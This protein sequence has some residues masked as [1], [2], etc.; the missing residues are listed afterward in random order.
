MLLKMCQYRH[1]IFIGKWLVKFRIIRNFLL[2]VLLD[3]Y[4][5]N[6]KGTYYQGSLFENKCACIIMALFPA[7]PNFVGIW[8]NPNPILSTMYMWR[9]M[10]A[11]VLKVDTV[12]FTPW[13]AQKI[14][15]SPCICRMGWDSAAWKIHCH[16]YNRNGEADGWNRFNSFHGHGH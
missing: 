12:L 6:I 11:F 9:F 13:R 10:C 2:Q 1:D 16:L 3:F 15:N 8:N 4:R 14:I 7:V 5:T